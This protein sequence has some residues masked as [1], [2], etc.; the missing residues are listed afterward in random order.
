MPN[1]T[2]N[3]FRNQ[4]QHSNKLK[5]LT[6]QTYFLFVTC[7]ALLENKAFLIQFTTFTK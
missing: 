1:K 2:I 6:S 4:Y 3:T 7:V 5:N